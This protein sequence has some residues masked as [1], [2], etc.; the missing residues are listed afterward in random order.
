MASIFN[1]L[2]SDSDSE[3]DTGIHPLEQE[4]PETLPIGLNAPPPNVVQVDAEPELN[5]Q[6]QQPQPSTSKEVQC[7]MCFEMFPMQHIQE[8]ADNCSPWAM[9]SEQSADLSEFRILV[10]ME[11]SAELVPELD[12]PQYKSL[13]KEEIARCATRLST[14]VK[15][16]NIR[17]R[18]LWEDFKAARKSKIGPLSN[19]KV[20][21]VG[22]PSIDDGGPK[23]E[24][25]CGKF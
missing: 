13:L 2:Y 24:L 15:R 22:E 23:R 1:D 19:L 10:E 5:I 9:K 21:F 18:F 6:V 20:V 16:I 25:F 7:P 12:M 11:E 17:R 8:H 14:N 3:I 4:R